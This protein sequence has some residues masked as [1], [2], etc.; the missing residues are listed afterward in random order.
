LRGVKERVYPVGRLDYHS[1]GLLLLT[2][3]GELANAIMSAT[4]HLPKTYVVKANGTLTADQE[5]QF[6]RGVPLSGKRTL[7]AG[8][9]LIHERR[10]PG[11]KCALRRPQSSDPP[12]VPAFR[13]AGGETAAGAHRPDRAGP[14]KPGEFRHLTAEEVGKLRRAL[15]RTAG[16]S[17]QERMNRFAKSSVRP[18][19]IAVVG[20]SAGA[21]RPSYG[22]A[23]YM[24]RAGYRIIP[25]NPGVAEV[26]GEKCYPSLDRSRSRSTSSISSAARSTCRRSW[27]PPFARARRRSGCRRAWCTKRPRAG[28]KRRAWRWSWTAAS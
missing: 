10:I 8:L 4:T 17:K 3:D 26:L 2:N 19:T 13:A 14:L 28:P 6:R 9:K 27:K 20:L 25:V 15:R 1:E 18:H 23:E 21:F 12:D 24:Q 16:A 5:E 11:T 7:P 22:V